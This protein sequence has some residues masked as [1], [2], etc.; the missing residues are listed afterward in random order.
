MT[1]AKGNVKGEGKG[2]VVKKS[3]MLCL[4]YQSK[5]NGGKKCPCGD[6]KCRYTHELCGTEEEYKAL[7][8]RVE[9]GKTRAEES[10][11]SGDTSKIAEFAKKFCKWGQTCRNH[12][13]GKCKKDHHYKGLDEYKKALNE[14]RKASGT[15]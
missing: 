14:I 11:K 3:R 5:W 12:Q 1:P 2:K 15:E 9:D 8:K 13:E 4:N 10:E 6:E 7:K